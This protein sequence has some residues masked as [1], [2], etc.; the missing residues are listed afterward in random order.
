MIVRCPALSLLLLLAVCPALCTAEVQQ[1][2]VAQWSFDAIECL[3]L[4]GE[5]E[6][7][8]GV[9]GTALLLDG[10]S[11]V[12]LRNSTHLTSAKAGFSVIAWVNPYGLNRDQQMIVAKNRYSLDE[13]QW[14]VMIDRDNRFRLYV[15]QDGWRTAAS[16]TTIQPGHWYQVAVVVHPERAELFVNGRLADSMEL[17][18]NVP[19]TDASLTLGGVDDD[20]FIRQTFW[21]A[22]D[23]VQVFD[24]P[25]T[26]AAL[27]DRYQ[28]VDATHEVPQI[29]TKEWELWDAKATLPNAEDIPQLEGVRF[30]VIKPHEPE[31]DGGYGFLHGVALAW[32]NGRLYA[33]WGHNKGLENTA[34]EEARGRVSDDGGRT[35]SDTFTI[36]S[37]EKDGK[38]A[39]SHGVF[40]SHEGAL[41][42]FMGSFYGAR[43]R[44]H[45]RAYLLDEP[46]GTW[47][48]RGVVIEGGFW[49][50]E[51]PVRMA[52]GN[53]IM[54]GIVVGDGNPAAVAISQGDDLRQWDLV[55][56][57]RPPSTTMWG[58]STTIVEGERILNIA[59]FGGRAVALAAVS[60]DYGRTWTPSQ[61]SNL[62]M[63]T[64]K[65]Y[66]GT[67]STGQRYLVCTTTADSGHRRS[68]L[69]I[70]VSDPGA[71][72]FNRVYRI[73]DAE[74]PEGPGDS[75]PQAALSYPYAVEHDGYLYVGYSNNGGRAG[76]NINSAELAV[77]P[78]SQLQCEERSD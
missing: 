55:V 48:F 57:S 37:G 25:L 54:G 49:P 22:I 11:L 6:L 69:T 62:P 31:K 21:G 1:Q 10:E 66:A 34:S 8:E 58:E 20:G 3:D 15:Y 41:W 38:L 36:D 4:R 14:G 74:F 12:V 65:P 18:R 28:P 23:E 42:A 40:L 44:V 47:Q 46:T 73:R 45:T 59:R 16:D 64:S 5:A 27:A 17:D 30:H 51:E 43:E 61:P 53:W 78:L 52:N 71:D 2:P 29:V 70:A 75:H 26:P 60:D 19:D 24:S 13:R 77:I 39:V 50:M 7:A 67:L 9:R 76:M 63:A 32:H 33:S 56:I 35:W 68:P 72:R